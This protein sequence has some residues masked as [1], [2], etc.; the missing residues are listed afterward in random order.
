MQAFAIAGTDHRQVH[1]HPLPAGANVQVNPVPAG[2][3]QQDADDLPQQVGVA[4][5]II[6]LGYCQADHLLWF[7]GTVVACGH[8]RLLFPDRG[9]SR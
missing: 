3:F 6:G 2:V 4:V 7:R 8:L 1:P 5:R 9:V